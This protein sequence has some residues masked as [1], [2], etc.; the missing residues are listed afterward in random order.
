MEKVDY[1]TT[2]Q[3][4]EDAGRFVKRKAREGW[5][6]VKDN[7]E[8]VLIC[9]PVASA[10]VAGVCKITSNAI[11]LHKVHKE[12]LIKNTYIYDPSLGFYWPMKRALTGA[13]KLEFD[14]RRK[15]GETT[16][17]ILRSMKVLKL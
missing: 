12:E 4:I 3:K 6:W 13:E 2:K 7:K 5:E 9:V 15:A 16:G 14:A 17:E 11:R 1:R 8:M 10:A